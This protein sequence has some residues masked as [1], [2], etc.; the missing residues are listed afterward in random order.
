MRLRK[1]LPCRTIQISIFFRSEADM[2]R[3]VLRKRLGMEETDGLSGALS[4]RDAA[5]QVLAVPN[6]PNLYFL[7]IGSRHAP[8]CAAQA[9]G[10]GRNR[11]LKWSAVGS[12]C[13]SASP[14]RAE[15]SKSLFS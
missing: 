9:P 5:P 14:C 3:P 15:Q 2:R 12:R 13:G 6:N 8:P 4:D 10:H 1:S 11:W 7:Q